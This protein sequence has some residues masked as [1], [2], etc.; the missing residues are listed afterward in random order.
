ML[1]VVVL[2]PVAGCGAVVEPSDRGPAA[3]DVVLSQQHERDRRVVCEQDSVPVAVIAST[4]RPLADGGPTGGGTV[5]P[6]P[7]LPPPALGQELVWA[8]S[9]AAISG[10]RAGP[11]LLSI[12]VTRR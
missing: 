11:F 12:G 8:G 1:L 9:A 10:V 7:V 6:G 5:V 4:S 3:S 2:L